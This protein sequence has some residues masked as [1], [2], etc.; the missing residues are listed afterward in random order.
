MKEVDPFITF[1]HTE[2]VIGN[3]RFQR[4][5]PDADWTIVEMS[6]V[7]ATN[8]FYRFFKLAVSTLRGCI[9]GNS[10]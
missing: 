9:G 8:F 6:Q 10:R 1:Q 5:D 2:I 4:P 7:V 3:S